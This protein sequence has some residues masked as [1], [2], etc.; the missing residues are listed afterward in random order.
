MK[1]EFLEPYLRRLRIRHIE[2]FIEADDVVLDIGCGKDAQFLRSISGSIRSGVGLDY[3]ANEYRSENLNIIRTSLDKG[4]HLKDNSFNKVFM[5]AV[6]EHIQDPQKLLK[7]VHRLLKTDGDLIMTVP[8]N[9][10]KHVLE[11]L[12]Y[13]LN[14]VSRAEIMDHK[15]YYNRQSLK[16]LSKKT[17]FF[18]T[19][20]DYFE[21]FM[22]NIAV[23]KKI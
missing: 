15:K 1:E 5:L 13:R 8:S 17:G 12:S 2:R 9:L 14:L 22:N 11:F 18:M 16:R 21:C 23:F 7:E 3:K 20:H 19:Y 4:L 6:L 10:A